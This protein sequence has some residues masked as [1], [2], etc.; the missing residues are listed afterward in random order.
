[1]IAQ[2]DETL[3]RWRKNLGTMIRADAPSNP[4]GGELTQNNF[5]KKL[6]LNRFLR[7][8]SGHFNFSRHLGVFEQNKKIMP[9][10]F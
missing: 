8:A 7:N 10:L 1:M 6:N 5:Q 4:C 9:I 2:I 3:H